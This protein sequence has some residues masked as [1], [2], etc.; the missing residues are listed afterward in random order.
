MRSVQAQTEMK[1]S[2][3]EKDSQFESLACDLLL[4][5]NA[6]KTEMRN[7]SVKHEKQV[8]VIHDSYK[9]MNSLRLTEDKSKA[10]TRCG[11]PWT[12]RSIGHQSHQAF[13]NQ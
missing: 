12:A 9:K 3:V 8:E 1:R 4:K 7:L 13:L 2:K 10:G 11:S 6:V 5:L